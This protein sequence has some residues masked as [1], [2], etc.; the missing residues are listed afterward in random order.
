MTPSRNLGKRIAT[1]RSQVSAQAGADIAITLLSPAGTRLLEAGGRWSTLRDDYIDG[2]CERHT[3]RVVSSQLR[4]AE[5]LAQWFIRYEADDP[6][7]EAL[8]LYV[9]NRRGGKTFFC[10]LAL[11]L[12]CLKYPRTHLGRAVV[13]CVVPTF[14]QQRELH[15]DIAK[16][17]PAAWFR[18][19]R[20]V[21]SKSEKCYKFINGAQ[22][23]IKSA[24]RPHLLKAGG[25]AA[26]A[27]NEAQQ[28]SSAG[29]LNALGA[30]I[31]SGGICWLAMNPPD[32]TKGLWAED[33]HDAI[34]KIDEKGTPILPF[35]RETA[36]PAALNEIINQQA[37]TR[38][39]KIAAVIDPKQAQRDA[40]GLWTSIRDRCY[41]K[42]NR[43]LHI[44]SDPK[45]WRNVTAEINSLTGMLN[46]ETRRTRGAGMD[47]QHN[48]W[49]AFTEASIRIAPVGAF[50]PEG[51]Y[52]FFVEYE[53]FNDVSMGLFW[54][55]E[56]LCEKLAEEGA[57]RGAA[58]SDY[59]LI[60]DGTGHHQGA[61]GVQRGRESDP[62]TWS[63]PILERYG[64]EP[65]APIERRKVDGG[66]RGPASI[67]T[68][69]LN[70]PVK[71]R[72]NVTNHLLHQ[73]RLIVS[74][75]CPETAES[76]R[77]CEAKNKK[78]WGRGAHLTDT[79]G[80]LTY[81]WETA[82][83]EHGIVKLPEAA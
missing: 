20:V 46:Q 18:D 30:N 37:R 73:M 57:K 76:F 50:V 80:Y 17:I 26:I 15:E 60:A 65:H 6:N 70:P 69:H 7:R 82:L 34:G 81:V 11:L 21:Y 51:T 33:L 78:P 71:V 47:F 12:F 56:E 43:N 83:I 28:V 75:D 22:L 44:R 55:E 66:K 23:W 35:A 54:S 74:P 36:F 62:A 32:T 58:P 4:A 3:L 45:N 5:Q 41:P 24:D 59:L 52:V 48:P 25:V 29:I 1:L 40:L 53:C 42:Y 77:M 63:F 67:T 16:I 19:G 79:V 68:S 9:D 10:V 14:P 38:F 49:C 72:L 61:S 8:E 2:D 27:V 39:A 31:D 64:W 13:W